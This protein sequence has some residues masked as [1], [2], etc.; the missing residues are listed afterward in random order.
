[1]TAKSLTYVEVDIPYC[2]LS[3]ATGACRAHLGFATG[4]QPVGMYFDGTAQWFTTGADLTGTADGKE[5]AFSLWVFADDTATNDTVFAGVTSVGGA[6]HRVLINIDASDRIQVV[7]KDISGTTVLDIISSAITTDRWVHVLCSVDLTDTNN[8]HLYI[9]DLEDLNTVTTYTNTA[10]DYT[11]ADWSLGGLADGTLLYGGQLTEFWLDDSY[12]DFSVEANRRDFID[13]NGQPVYAGDTGQLPTSAQPLIYLSSTDLVT[14]YSNKGSGGSFTPEET[15]EAADPIFGIDKCYNTI[16]TCQDRTS[17]DDNPVTIRFCLD[18]A[19]YPS[20]IEA[21]PCVISVAYNP[22][23]LSLGENLGQR[24][25]LVIKFTDHKHN[26]TGSGFDKYYAERDYEAWEQGTFFGRWR[27]RHLYLRGRAIRL[28]R[29]LD[30][31]AIGD[32]ETHNYLIEDFDGP[33]ENGVYTLTAKDTLKLA[34]GDRAQAPVLS[35]GKLLSAITDSDTTAT[36]SPTGIG[37]SE[38]PASGK[39]AIGGK[40]IVSFTRAGDTLT[41]TRAQNNTDAIAH[42]GDDRCQLV[43]EYSGETPAYIIEE[44]FTDY[45]GIPS[46]YI[47]IDDWDTEVESY[48]SEVY[49]AVIAE[50]VPVKTL[51]SELIQQAAL[52]MWWDDENQKIRLQVLHEIS[53]DA[54][55]LDNECIIA[56]TFSCVDQPSK[57]ITQV[58]TYYAQRNPLKKVS[59]DDNYRSALA[60][61]S[62]QVES[63]FGQAAIKVIRSRW[64]PAFGSSIADRVNDLLIARYQFPPRKFVFS[65]DKHN[66]GHGISLGSGYY[67]QHFNLQN[68]DG[69]LESVPIQITS[70]NVTDTRYNIEAEEFSFTDDVR[71]LVNRVITVDTNVL[72]FN[73]RTIHDTL[74]PEPTGEESPAINVTCIVNEG[75]VIGSSDVDTPAFDV[76]T[77]PSGIDIEIKLLGRLQGKG[78]NGGWEPLVYGIAAENG[79]T[80]LYT[81]VAI[82]VDCTK[83]APKIYGGGGGGASYNLVLLFGGGGGGGAGWLPGTGGIGVYTNGDAGTLDSPGQG[84]NSEQ[85]NPGG[86]GGALGEA[87]NPADYGGTPGAAGNAVDGD[88]YITYSGTPDIKGLEVN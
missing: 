70:L 25:T 44:L 71:D 43:L 73:L 53:K 65:L 11:L 77:W 48:L 39:V 42:A 9:D 7:A 34:D 41:I 33:N 56:D 59:D 69:S 38:Y 16:A 67:I 24:G 84:G 28:I 27:K 81:R 51:V 3:Y 17:F 46:A 37:N 80:A 58:W 66:S 15:A 64:I 47:P 75:V 68:T 78:G 21:I 20:D 72:D 29:G 74:Y 26:D 76:G 57:R 1:M 10:I 40:E 14:W 54:N 88:S 82:D 5:L 22:P 6:T 18:S 61:V 85:E 79:G 60:N 49:T 86:T 62:A 13:A 23:V 36:L 2:D 12:I 30:G 83:G 31:E 52:S 50:P 35:T 19:H 87:G 4:D 55:V 45:A 32:M 63:D 8:R